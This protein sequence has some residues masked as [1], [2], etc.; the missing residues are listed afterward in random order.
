MSADSVCPLIMSWNLQ[1]TR[2]DKVSFMDNCR[3]N[4]VTG[5]WNPSPCALCTSVPRDSQ[6]AI[7]A[8]GSMAGGRCAILFPTH[9][10][11]LAFPLVLLS[12]SPLHICGN[13]TP[14]RAAAQGSMVKQFVARSYSMLQLHN[15]IHSLDYFPGTLYRLYKTHLLSPYFPPT[16]K[17]F[18]NNPSKRH[19]LSV[20]PENGDHTSAD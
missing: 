7:S 13:P 16:Q 19:L 18:W 2:A 20:L 8:F 15:A 6:N 14:F 3:L 1:D 10:P 9:K 17:L 11:T 4:I 5:L 12:A